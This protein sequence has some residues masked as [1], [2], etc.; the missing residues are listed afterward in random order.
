[1]MEDCIGVGVAAGVWADGRLGVGGVWAALSLQG[2]TGG[3]CGLMPCECARV[4]S[5]C[6]E[7]GCIG[8]GVRLQACG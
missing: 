7:A 1:M 3:G 6:C 5:R 2:C 8:A 4:L